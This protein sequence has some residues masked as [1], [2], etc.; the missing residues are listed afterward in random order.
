MLKT[1]HAKRKTRP[2][3]PRG[4]CTGLRLSAHSL[5]LLPGQVTSALG[6]GAAQ[7]LSRLGETSVGTNVLPLLLLRSPGASPAV[8]GIRGMGGPCGKKGLKTCFGVLQS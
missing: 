1:S 2:S 7:R 5:L 6:V 3:N 4:R 8:D